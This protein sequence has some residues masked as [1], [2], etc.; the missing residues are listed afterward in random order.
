MYKTFINRPI[1]AMVISIV[2]VLLG[3]LAITGLPVEQY[4]DITPPVVEVTASYTGADA[5]VVADA[6]AVPIEESVMGSIHTPNIPRMIS[7]P[8]FE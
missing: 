6:V 7:P 4:P 2:I 8:P 3:G 5:E 1:F